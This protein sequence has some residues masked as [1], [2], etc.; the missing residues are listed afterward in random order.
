MNMT[1]K[2][3]LTGRLTSDSIGAETLLFCPCVLSVTPRCRDCG[4]YCG[5]SELTCKFQRLECNEDWRVESVSACVWVEVKVS[6]HD[7]I[8]ILGGLKSRTSAVRDFNP[9][10]LLSQ[11]HISYNKDLDTSHSPHKPYRIVRNIPTC[12]IIIRPDRKHAAQLKRCVLDIA[13]LLV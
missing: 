8:P 12:L 10:V 1:L 6:M 4:R 5:Q 11:G 13:A 3:R 2:Y 9:P 7:Q